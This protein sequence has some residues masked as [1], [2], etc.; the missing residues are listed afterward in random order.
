V[1]A[2]AKKSPP[3]SAAAIWWFCFRRAQ[4]GWP[5]G[6]AVSV[7][8]LE[9]ANQQRP[10]SVAC[11][12]YAVTGGRPKTT[13]CYWRHDL[14]PASGQLDDKENPRARALQPD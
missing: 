5:A 14:F 6:P 4:P 7:V 2:L 12:S 8:A 1:C 10:L 11:I 13:I 9:P 3:G